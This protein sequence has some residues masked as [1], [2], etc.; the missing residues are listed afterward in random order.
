MLVMLNNDENA[1]CGSHLVL[2]LKNSYKDNECVCM[3]FK[4]EW[5]IFV[6]LELFDFFM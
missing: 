3:Y 5:K 2:F 4:L 6:A 1:E